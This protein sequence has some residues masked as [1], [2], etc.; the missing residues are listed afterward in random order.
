ML[1]RCYS[2][3]CRGTIYQRENIK[4]DSE[5]FSFKN[6]YLWATGT[7][8]NYR[9]D[10]FLDKDILSNRTKIYSCETCTFISKRL[11]TALSYSRHSRNIPIGITMQNGSY[12]ATIT[13]GKIHLGRFTNVLDSYLAYKVAKSAYM[14]SIILDEVRSGSLSYGCYTKL[15]LEYEWIETK[16]ENQLDKKYNLKSNIDKFIEN[17]VYLKRFCTKICS[18]VIES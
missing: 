2:D 7:M 13:H 5:W 6:F 1:R 8:S 3:E 12:L 11:N 10:L 16:F 15:Y 17:N 18:E 14:M 4:V 9:D